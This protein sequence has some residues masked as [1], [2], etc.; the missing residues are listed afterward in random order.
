[1]RKQK[2]LLYRINQTL[3][4]LRKSRASLTEVSLGGGYFSHTKEFVKNDG[5]GWSLR[6]SGSQ[7]V[8]KNVSGQW[9]HHDSYFFKFILNFLSSFKISL[10]LFS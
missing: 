8:K 6:V 9:S 3:W 2:L 10:C 5:N 4:G 1:M 7:W